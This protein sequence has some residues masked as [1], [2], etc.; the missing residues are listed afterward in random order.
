MKLYKLI[1]TRYAERQISELYS[2]IADHSSEA[3][4][5]RFVGGLIDRCSTLMAFPERG[6]RRD[7]VRPNLRTFGYRRRVTIAFSVEGENVVVHGVYYG[8]Q[9]FGDMP[10]ERDEGEE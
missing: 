1:F 8:G 6:T 7:D 10:S 3:R 9:N 2:Y 4:A 5:E